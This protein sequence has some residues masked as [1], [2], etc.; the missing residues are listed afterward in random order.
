MREKLLTI[1]E[2]AQYLGITEKQVID[3]SEKSIIPAYKVGGI[4]L[5]FKKEQL[6]A[7]KDKIQPTI[8]E[9]Y[10]EYPFQDRLSDFFYY[11]DF[12]I[13][14]LLII[15]ILIYHIFNL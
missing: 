1:R 13:L 3:L 4:Y 6:D 8:R 15:S 12:Y 2:A 5:R 10:V 14:S 9:D 11:N 7:I